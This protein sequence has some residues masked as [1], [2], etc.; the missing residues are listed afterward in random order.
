MLKTKHGSAVMCLLA[1]G[2]S[3]WVEDDFSPSV[4][5]SDLEAG[6]SV[7]VNVLEVKKYVSNKGWGVAS[8]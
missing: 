4:N 5:I 7:A 8:C 1:R 3:E 6:I 2:V